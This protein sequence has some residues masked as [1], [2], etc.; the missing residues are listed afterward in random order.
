MDFRRCRCGVILW[1][2]SPA[3]VCSFEC[4]AAE[5]GGTLRRNQA[6]QAKVD[7]TVRQAR[8][9]AESAAAVEDFLAKIDGPERATSKAQ[10]KWAQWQLKKV[11]AGAIPPCSMERLRALAAT[12]MD[13]LPERA[14][15]ARKPAKEA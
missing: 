12:P 8:L 5:Y 14:K 6:R 10:V 15:K 7:T 1:P 13:G 4:L 2:G 11:A 9:E 3:L